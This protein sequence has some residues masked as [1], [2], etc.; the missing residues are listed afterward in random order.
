VALKSAGFLYPTADNT[1][2]QSQRVANR[3]ALVLFDSLPS[4][5]W[6]RRAA[7]RNELRTENQIRAYA[8]RFVGDQRV[9]AKTR[10]FLHSWLN[11]EHI[12]D[13]SKHAEKYPGFNEEIV[14]DL[15]KSLDRFLEHIVWSDESDYRQFFLSET[16]FTTLRL[17]EY[18]GKEWAA[19]GKE[20]LVPIQSDKAVGLLHHPYLLSGLAYHDSTSPIHRGVFLIRFMLGR[21]LRPPS[22]AFTPLSPDLHPD[23]TTRERVDLQTSP[24]SCQVCHKKINSLGFALE[25]W[26]AVGKWRENEGKK[27]V[28]T[29]GSYIAKDGTEV[30]F[31][32]SRDL[33]KY[34]AESEDAQRAF[35]SRAFQHFVKQPAAAYGAD[36]LDELTRYFRENE[37]NVKKL[38]VE[39]AVVATRPAWNES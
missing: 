3:L 10:D 18:Y 5:R 37:C 24:D 26:D 8:E 7:E 2:S 6:L 27:A 31:L 32:D 11:L 28:D 20:G 19:G 35:V 39:I 30:K 14:D 4:D 33:A 36:T 29:S 9:R 22:E 1:S 21:V 16:R 15:R 23:L 12:S 38:L 34:L 17:G 13:I 25:N